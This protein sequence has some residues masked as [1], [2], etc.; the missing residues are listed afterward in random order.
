MISM[1]VTLLRG[2]GQ[3]KTKEKWMKDHS[4]IADYMRVALC[5]GGIVKKD[6]GFGRGKGNVGRRDLNNDTYF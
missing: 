3:Y 6:V 2:V 5:N 4:V 1:I